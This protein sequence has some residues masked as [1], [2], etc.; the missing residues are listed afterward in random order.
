MGFSVLM[1]ALPVAIIGVGLWLKPEPKCYEPAPDGGPLREVACPSA[2]ASHA[3]GG[4]SYANRP[5]DTQR[6]GFG[7]S[8]SGFSGGS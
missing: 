5:E 6:G 3:S 1:F 4:T 2:S 7:R 8:A